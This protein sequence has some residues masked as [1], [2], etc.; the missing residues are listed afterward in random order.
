MI[1]NTGFE[2]GEEVIITD[3]VGER[4]FIFRDIITAINLIR[5]TETVFVYLKESPV[6]VE[7]N[8]IEKIL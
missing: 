8:Q 7:I 5:G 2:I 6:V 1:N 3:I 4:T